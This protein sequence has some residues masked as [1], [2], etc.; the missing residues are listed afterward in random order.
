[1][2]EALLYSCDL[3]LIDAESRNSSR[4]HAD[5][6]KT[7]T[8]A[9]LIRLH[10]QRGLANYAAKNK[11]LGALGR[12]GQTLYESSDAQQNHKNKKHTVFAGIPK[13]ASMDMLEIHLNP[14]RSLLF[15]KDMC[16]S[17]NS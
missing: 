14:E 15:E 10:Y 9:T 5:K 7:P 13:N 17:Y 12:H 3:D 16:S 1:M 11:K 6:I 2:K 4:N 8:V